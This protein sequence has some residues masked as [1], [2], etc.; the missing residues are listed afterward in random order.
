MSYYPTILDQMTGAPVFMSG[1]LTFYMSPREL[2]LI[3]YT[4]LYG[5][6]WL[7]FLVYSGTVKLETNHGILPLSEYCT[8]NRVNINYD[9]LRKIFSSSNIC[10][11]QNFHLRGRFLV[12]ICLQNV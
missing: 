1:D 9:F 12:W 2:P 6:S 11:S 10:L 5:T 7:M 4:W 8:N 3:T